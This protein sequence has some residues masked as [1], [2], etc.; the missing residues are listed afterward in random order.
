MSS[1]ATKPVYLLSPGCDQT[2][3]SKFSWHLQYLL[4][5]KIRTFRE[6]L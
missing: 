4:T 1:G 5:H 2:S 6:E 3:G